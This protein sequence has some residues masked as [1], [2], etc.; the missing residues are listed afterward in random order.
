MD[1]AG[2]FVANYSLETSPEKMAAD[3]AKKI[4]H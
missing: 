3:L 1:P 2:A 4:L